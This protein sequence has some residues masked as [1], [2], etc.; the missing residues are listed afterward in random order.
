[1]SP[2]IPVLFHLQGDVG[3]QLVNVV[4]R[5]AVA[6]KR[7]LHRDEGVLV[8]VLDV[9]KRFELGPLRSTNVQLDLREKRPF[10]IGDGDGFRYVDVKALDDSA[11]QM[12]DERSFK[13]TFLIVNFMATV[14]MESVL[15]KCWKC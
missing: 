11:F 15:P 1:M 14:F 8:G 4:G 7:L 6:E 3:R 5:L 12:N 9:S 2:Y 13:M 10:E